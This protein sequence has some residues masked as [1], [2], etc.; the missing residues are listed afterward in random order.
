MSTVKE[1]AEQAD[2][3][4][5]LTLNSVKEAL[6]QQQQ[7]KEQLT[8]VNQL[9]KSKISPIPSLQ[10]IK[11]MLEPVT[12]SQ[13]KDL[14]PPNFNDM[15]KSC[16]DNYSVDFLKQQCF[17]EDLLH[18]TINQFEIYG[19]QHLVKSLKNV[20][21]IVSLLYNLSPEE[22]AFFI[23]ETEKNPEKIIAKAE[24]ISKTNNNNDKKYL[25][26]PKITIPL[27]CETLQATL[28][29]LEN[30]PEDIKTTVYC[31]SFTILM[32]IYLVLAVAFLGKANSS[33]D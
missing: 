4:K 6:L 14:M 33:D 31:V 17:K 30:S 8:G 16:K 5:H 1:L 21:P 12:M 25:D 20:Q 2:T 22:Q 26:Y 9:L 11:Q 27:I 32:T 13:V 19:V 3:L 23:T 29:F 28:S 15:I 24:T 18:Q 10:S 7:L